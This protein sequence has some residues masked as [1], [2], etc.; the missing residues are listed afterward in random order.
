MKAEYA[1]KISRMI[2]HILAC[3]KFS[4]KKINKIKQNEIIVIVI[5]NK[6]K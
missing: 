6:I 4:F 3:Y 1:K 5:I 2:W